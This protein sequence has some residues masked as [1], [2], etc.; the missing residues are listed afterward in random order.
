M[1]AHLTRVATDDS[2]TNDF[3]GAKIGDHLM[4]LQIVNMKG[5]PCMVEFG[6]NSRELAEQLVLARRGLVDTVDERYF[7]GNLQRSWQLTRQVG[8]F[9]SPV[10]RTLRH[11][12]FPGG[13]T[14]GLF[15]ELNGLPV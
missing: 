6:G 4:R 9:G 1:A 3:P 8:R 13:Q 2:E 15:D 12:L 10:Q 14:C 5:E 7:G 11:R